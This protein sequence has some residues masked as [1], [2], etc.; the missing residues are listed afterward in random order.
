MKALYVALT[1]SALSVAQP[2]GGSFVGS[3]TAAFDSRTFIKL[4][5]KTVNGA[6]AG[7]ISLGNFEVDLQGVVSR[8]DA[9]RPNLTP[10]SGVTVKGS[11]L[12]FFSKDG[13][14]TD[15]FELRLLE[16][17]DAELHFLLNDDDRRQLADSG[18]PAPKPIRVTKTS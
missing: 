10:I 2:P 17:G 4:E 3:W 14:D 5:I 16:N 9:A 8:A 15:Q 11:T 12:T 7:G 1:I 6:I 18:V 13:N